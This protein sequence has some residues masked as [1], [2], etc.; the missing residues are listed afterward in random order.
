MRK[1]KR[2]E[3]DLVHRCLKVVPARRLIRYRLLLTRVLS[4]TQIY[5]QCIIRIQYC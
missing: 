5:T 4:I 3:N 2:T 1:I